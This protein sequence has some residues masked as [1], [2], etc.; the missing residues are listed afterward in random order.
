MNFALLS[1]RTTPST[2]SQC[3]P[4]FLMVRV[5]RFLRLICYLVEMLRVGISITM[6]Q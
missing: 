4:Q 1:M 3:E 5:W 6:V 2:L